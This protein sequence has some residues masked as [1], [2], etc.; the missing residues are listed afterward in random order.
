MASGQEQLQP[1]A[2]RASDWTPAPAHPREE[3]RLEALAGLGL[4]DTPPEARFDRLTS[5]VAHVLDAPVVLISLVGADRQW[6][7]SACGLDAQST[8]RDL[9]VCAHAILEAGP[10]LVL[11]DLQASAPFSMHPMVTGEP[12]FRSY[13]GRILRTPGGLPLG[14]LCVLDHKP[15]RFNTHELETL[16]SFGGLVE[17]E[18]YARMRH[19]DD[20]AR[21]AAERR[22]DAKTGLASR[23]HILEV[24]DTRAAEG[25]AADT[26]PTLLVFDLDDFTLVNRSMGRRVGDAILAGVGRRLV[27]ALPDTV[28]TARLERDAFAVFFP[29]APSEE[30]AALLET[31]RQALARPFPAEG[32]SLHLTAHAGAVSPIAP[33]SA[34]S[35]LDLAEETCRQAQRQHLSL[36]LASDPTPKNLQERFQITVALREALAS[37]AGQLRMVYQPKV[38][39]V[40]G[41]V[42]GAEALIRWQ[43]PVLGFVSPG[44]FVPIAE[45]MGL[46][47][48]LSRFVLET[49]CAQIA[50]WRA[51]GLP[52]VPVAVNLSLSDFD[53]PELAEM[54]AGLLQR[55]GLPG[56]LLE[57]EITEQIDSADKKNIVEQMRQVRELGVG[58]SV[59]DFGT[60]YSSLAWLASLP[61]QTLKIDRSF[62]TDFAT[63]PEVPPLMRGSL[64]L[65]QDL[66]L[67]TVI[68]GVETYAELDFI[69][70]CGGDV[71]QGWVFSRPLEV[72]AFGDLAARSVWHR[73]PLKG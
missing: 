19:A 32:R 58:L 30:N 70:D 6:F 40:T 10:L 39:A 51:A 23:A 59:D 24:L 45:E 20:K 15:R 69:R 14:T 67:K 66:N 36:L 43:H 50:A 46:N 49:V 42:V 34:A 56:E 64:S 25:W 73:F 71:V 28:L 48:A 55:H 22:V 9:S 47:W 5:L 62:V 2:E 68:E 29:P 4:L 33:L 57:L 12:G 11:E 26:P 60:G 54:V 65:A 53:R 61:I 52:E 37:P 63:R 3:A 18:L 27:G 72:D 31:A 41:A 7:K 44:K 38:S 13:V 8:P 21:L 1:L 17:E 16:V 35:W